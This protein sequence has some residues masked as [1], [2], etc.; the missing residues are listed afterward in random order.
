MKRIIGIFCLALIGIT[1]MA[2][3]ITVKGTVKDSKDEPLIGVAVMLEG[4]SKI[5]TVTDVDGNY[6]ITLPAGKR[7][8]LLFSSIGYKD[9]TIELAGRA[10]VDVV[11]EDDSTVLEETVVVG[12]GAMRRSDLTGSLTSVKIDDD[13]AAKSASLDQMLEGRAAGVQVLSSSSSPDA[14]VTIR[15]RGIA[16]F[17]GTQTLFM[18]LTASL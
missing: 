3:N 11:L 16:S 9:K 15:V 1:A 17:S 8:K 12:Y 6:Q 14:G 2:Q 4:N 5:G 18:L 10:V 7:Q 13:K